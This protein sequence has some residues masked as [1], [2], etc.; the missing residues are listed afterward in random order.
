MKCWRDGLRN[1]GTT[2]A[3]YYVVKWFPQD[4]SDPKP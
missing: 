1:I 4:L 2:P 3:I